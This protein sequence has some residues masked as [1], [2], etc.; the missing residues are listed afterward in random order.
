MPDDPPLES[1][2]SRLRQRDEAA[3][4]VV[5]RE[6]VPKAAAKIRGK[7]GPDAR[8]MSAE[9]A[10]ASAC[11]TTFRRLQEG[12][13]ANGLSSYDDLLNLLVVVARNKLIDALRKGIAEE[14]WEASARHDAQGA[15]ADNA[16]ESP[17]L[18][19]IFLAEVDRKMDESLAKLDATLADDTERLVF[20]AKL[21][22]LTER[23]IVARVEA[24]IGGRMTVFMVREHWR[25]IRARSRRLFPELLN[26][27]PDD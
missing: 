6:I 1:L 2:S 14:K 26:G 12:L 18:R 10:V 3:W 9:E 19:A 16:R 27:S 15:E 25:T 23:E 22:G 7:L 4:E 20:L 21:D 8:W 24:E 17:V 11:R 13:L 5:F